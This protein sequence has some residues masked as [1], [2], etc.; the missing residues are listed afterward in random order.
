MKKTLI[1]G[2][3]YVELINY[4]E[5]E[6]KANE[7]IALDECESLVSGKGYQAALLFQK[8]EFPYYLAVKLGSGDYGKRC[9]DKAREMNIDFVSN[10][11]IGGCKYRIISKDSNETVAFTIAGSEYEIDIDN[12]ELTNTEEY[13]ATIL[14]SEMLINNDDVLMMLSIIASIDKPIYFVIDDRIMEVEA[15]ILEALLALKPIIFIDEKEAKTLYASDIM[16]IDR[17]LDDIH[18]DNENDVYLLDH[19]EGIYHFDGKERV[20][21][22]LEEEIDN[23]LLA[24]G[25]VLARNSNVDKR[26]ALLFAKEVAS[27]SIQFIEGDISPLKDRLIRM[28]AYK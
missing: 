2:A 17:I 8:F 26:N 3:T 28:I 11:G 21:M 13:M 7:D 18:Y 25:Y 12:L 9:Q 24:I 27:K 20:L 23:S 6:I 4:V 14:F 5:G 16:E 19:H 15:D 1:L 22:P 10:E